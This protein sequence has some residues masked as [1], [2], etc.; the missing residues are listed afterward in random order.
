[1]QIL[2]YNIGSLG[3]T[4]VA[5][6]AL[7]AVRD[8]FP[9]A[10]ITM[11]TDEQPGRALVQACDIF[12]GSGLIDD[13]IVY[14]VGNPAAMAR[15]LLQ[16]RSR[17]YD[18]LVY[19]IRAYANDLRIRRDKLFFR[20]AGIKRC[21]GMR[22]LC[23][24]PTKSPGNP[25][26]AV[27]HVADTLLVRLRADGLKTP[28]AGQGRVGVHIGKR[29]HENV[30]RWLSGLSDD[31]GRPWIAIGPGSKMPCKIWP[32]ERYLA[33]TNQLVGE[34]NLW[35]V[36]F[37]GPGDRDLGQKLLQELEGGY[38]AAGV[39]GV[40]DSMAAME[41][42][43]LF[44]GN[45][46]G[47]MHMAAAS[48]LRCVALFTSRQEPGLWYPYGEGHIVLRTPVPCE[49]CLLEECI[50]RKMECILSIS[51]EQVLQA[52]R[53][54]LEDKNRRNNLRFEKSKRR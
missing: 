20:L 32:F 2:I 23:K 38:V 34:Y 16:L 26:P 11:L 15:L 41:R 39:L 30:N 46:T 31:G 52:C 4:L 43:L 13:Y 53:I 36:I 27:P 35:P 29:E 14:P 47:T 21:I 12:D 1:M 45:D 54:V 19:L 9:D 48:G 22:G 3:D 40:R 10:H 28:P 42:C 50:E 25:M 37:G 5:V 17:K 18:S 8:N 24:R 7:W 51:M 6:P 49:G 33:V 44:L